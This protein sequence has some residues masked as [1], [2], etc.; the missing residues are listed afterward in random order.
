MRS[1]PCTRVTDKWYGQSEIFELQIDPEGHTRRKQTT[2]TRG[3]LNLA[4]K[5]PIETENGRFIDAS[6]W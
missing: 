2:S 4:I 1:T 5:K 6:S 3:A